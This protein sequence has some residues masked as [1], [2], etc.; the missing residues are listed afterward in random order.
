MC[1]TPSKAAKRAPRSDLDSLN[2]FWGN[3][4]GLEAF[5]GLECM[6][7]SKLP[8]PFPMNPQQAGVLQFNA[9]RINN[10]KMVQMSQGLGSGLVGAMDQ[11]NFERP[12][13][14]LPQSNTMLHG[15]SAPKPFASNSDPLA[16]QLPYAL[17]ERLLSSSQQ[18]QQP[19]FQ[20][21]VLP[22]FLSASVEQVLAHQQDEIRGVLARLQSS[23]AAQANPFAQQ[24][25]SYGPSVHVLQA[26]AAAAAAASA[27]QA[28]GPCGP[29]A[30]SWGP[31][32]MPT[33]AAPLFG[34]RQ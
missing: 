19:S 1:L 18:Q 31:M 2:P 23:Q 13:L 4:L 7:M 14:L 34:G 5:A 24:P 8:F 28:A 6:E 30:L 25:T 9:E 33:G 12:T 29:G 22:S 3:G 26:I 10:M 20:S 11:L 15:T 17:I 16:C 32:A 21:A 27:A